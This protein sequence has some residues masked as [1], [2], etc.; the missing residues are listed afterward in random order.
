MA[1]IIR[2]EPD[3]ERSRGG[4]ELPPVPGKK[5][6]R[7]PEER[8]RRGNELPPARGKKLP[9]VYKRD[10]RVG[11]PKTSVLKSIKARSLNTMNKTKPAQP[12]R[13]GGR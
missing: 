11:N 6:P 1:S 12:N 4:K 8:S 7:V 5:L 10:K 9:P 2:P 13:R 3:K